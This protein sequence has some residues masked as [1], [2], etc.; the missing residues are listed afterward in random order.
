MI[1][2]APTASTVRTNRNRAVAR[3]HSGQSPYWG[4]RWPLYGTAEPSQRIGKRSLPVGRA[5]RAVGVGPDLAC[6]G[7]LAV[8]AFGMAGA[9]LAGRIHVMD[10]RVVGLVG[11]ARR[12]RVQT[13]RLAHAPRQRWPS[14]PVSVS[15]DRRGRSH[16]SRQPQTPRIQRRRSPSTRR[17]RSS[18]TT[19]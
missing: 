3:R 18:L 1:C 19:W 11:Y 17:R 5:R 7:V 15:R 16:L 4:L 13:Q 6:H 14:A 12:R 8:P 10:N 2:S 9:A